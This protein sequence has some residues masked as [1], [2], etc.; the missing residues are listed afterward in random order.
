MKFYGLG[1]LSFYPRNIEFLK[2][3][4]FESIFD[5][6]IKSKKIA[7]INE[8]SISIELEEYYREHKGINVEPLILKSFLNSNL[9]VIQIV[10]Q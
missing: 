6:L 1:W 9:K 5:M 3:N 7:I 10:Q 2:I 8:G 4:G